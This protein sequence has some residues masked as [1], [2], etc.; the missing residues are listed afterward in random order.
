LGRGNHPRVEAQQRTEGG[1]QGPRRCVE[2]IITSDVWCYNIISQQSQ[3]ERERERE[4]DRETERETE[5]EREREREREIER[6]RE[7][8][9]HI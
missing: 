8:E 7:R 3:R 5:R 6:Q 9:G 1:S 4:R 2:P